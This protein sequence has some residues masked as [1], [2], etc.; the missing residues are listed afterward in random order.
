MTAYIDQKYLAILEPKLDLPKRKGSGELVARCP[1]CG[2]SAKSRYKRRFGISVKS[3]GAVC[4]C[5]NCG[6]SAPFGK[7]LKDYFPEIYNDYRIE[8]FKESKQFETRSTQQNTNGKPKTL[9]QTKKL[10]LVMPIA[11][12][13]E[14]ISYLDQRGVDA[15][16]LD[17]FLWVPEFKP[18]LE[19]LNPIAETTIDG[20][21]M[22]LPL[23]NQTGTLVG[24]QS[25][26]M[27]KEAKLRYETHKIGDNTVIFVPKWINW[28]EPVIVSEGVF[29]ALSVTNGV[30][31]LSAAL[32][33][34]NM[35]K[36]ENNDY[37]LCYDNEP[38]NEHI[39]RRMDNA[40]KKGMKVFF[41]RWEFNDLNDAKVAGW[42]REDVTDYVK[43]NSYS[44]ARARLIFM[45]WKKGA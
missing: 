16:R 9:F 40:I 45:D 7:F 20:S 10:D 13:K 38:N 37:I 1:V 14:A 24:I 6:Y 32:D 28:S 8:K 11:T 23:R 19:R 44:G 34:H 31:K 22:I 33:M 42:S 41:P 17:A 12:S 21:C 4:G 2:D 5:F 36:Q 43:E 29:D 15:D 35:T 26:S 3:D 25:R 18:F 27:I 39:V 30:A